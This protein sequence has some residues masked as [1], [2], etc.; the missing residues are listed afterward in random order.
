ELTVTPHVPQNQN[1][2]RSGIDRRTT[3]HVGYDIYQ[4]VRKGIAKAFGSAKTVAVLRNMPHR[5]LAKARWQFTLATAA[6][7]LVRLPNLLAEPA[8][9]PGRPPPP[10]SPPHR[11]RPTTRKTRPTSNI[12]LIYRSQTANLTH[13]FSSLLMGQGAAARL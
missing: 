10:P 4:R 9:C 5:R 6:Y 13:F 1:D 12:L 2:R 8:A 7:N 3:R 11:S